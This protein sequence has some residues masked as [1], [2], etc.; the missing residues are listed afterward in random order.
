MEW[1]ERSNVFERMLKYNAWYKMHRIVFSTLIMWLTNYWTNVDI[2]VIDLGWLQ[3]KGAFF[4][5][6]PESRKEV[7]HY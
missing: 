4:V 5:S 2:D 7:I 6:A 3:R 1:S